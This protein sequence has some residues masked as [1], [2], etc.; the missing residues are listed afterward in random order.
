M[1]EGDSVFQLSERLQPLT[2]RLVTRTQLRVPRYA[3]V[4]FEGAELTRL[5]PYGKHLFM[6]FDQQILHTHLKMEG[7]WSVHRKGVQ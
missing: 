5:W 7:T 3:T 4:R 6:R 1:P 2:G